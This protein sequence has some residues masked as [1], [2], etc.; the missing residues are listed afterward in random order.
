MTKEEAFERYIK[1]QFMGAVAQLTSLPATLPI[2]S[3]IYQD[4]FYAGWEAREESETQQTS[5]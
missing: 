5:D 4:L 3:N 1:S 2:I